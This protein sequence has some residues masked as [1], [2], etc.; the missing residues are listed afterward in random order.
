MTTA[1]KN[2][3][4]C[5]VRRLAVT[6]ASA[7]L[8]DSQLLER[9]AGQQDESAF[10]ALLRRHGPLVL[11]VCRRVLRDWHDAEDA[12]QATF[13]ALAQQAGSL[14]RPESLGPW[15]HGVAAR[16]ALKARSR[17]ARRWVCEREAAATRPT[18]VEHPDEVVWRDL[19]P[20]LDEAVA[21]LPESC[22][23]PFVLCY[24]EGRTVSEAARDL[25]WPRGTVATRL[26]LARRRLR[27]RLASRGVALSAA[28]LAGA[29][30]GN[31]ASAVPP[32]SLLVATAQ[33]ATA[34]ADHA[35]ATGAGP[36][37]AALAQ[38]G[39]AM[40]VTR[41]KV[42]ALL[43]AVGVAGAGLSLYGQRPQERDSRPAAARESARPRELAPTHS[44]RIAATVNG[45][46][47]LAEEV[48]AAAYLSLP[49]AHN[50]TALDRSRRITAVWRKTLDRVIE[51]EVI[52]QGA[53]TA[54]NKVGNAN[55]PKKLQEVAANE[56]D[57]QWVETVKRSTGLKDEQLRAFLRA[58]DV[59]GC[60][61]TPVGARLHRRAVPAEPFVSGAC[62]GGPAPVRPRGRPK[63]EGSHHHRAEAAQ[64]IEYAGAGQGDIQE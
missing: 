43:L 5:Y 51:R 4:I 62:P 50:L 33:A 35:I 37:T 27:A 3:A 7:E 2:P 29:L 58:G 32:G 44:P 8:S 53:F 1:E 60:G 46:A 31:G 17:A 13:V 11:G 49:D 40:L 55:M 28:A 52:V 9:F 10:A 36:A 39:K 12:F 22:R 42:V 64:V 14:R 23:V 63:G 20:V 16:L 45:E 56:F 18:T 6:L 15:L 61:A 34:A 41:A 19:R 38:G 24:L 48:Y 47:I 54:L 57:R 25:G 59:P 21:S 30:S 26:A